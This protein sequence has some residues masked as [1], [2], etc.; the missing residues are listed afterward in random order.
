[1]RDGFLPRWD[2]AWSALLEDLAERG[3]LE[4]TMVLAW[5]EFGRTPMVNSTGGRDHYP[6]VFSAALAGGGIQGGRVVGAS[7]S[8]GAFPLNN[9]KTPQDVLATVYR[10]LGVDTA[11]SYLDFSGRPVS[12]LPS[13]SVIGELF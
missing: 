11:A 1:M 4:T 8:W 2:Q 9:P 3:L 6:N 13:G 7:D 10:H 5:G 12:V